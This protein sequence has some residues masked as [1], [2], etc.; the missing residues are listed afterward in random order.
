MPFV[1]VTVSMNI[2]AMVSGPSYRITSSRYVRFF[3]VISSSVSPHENVYG[4]GSITWTTP[5]MPGSFGI[6]RGSPVSCIV[7]LVAPW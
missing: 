4:H 1:P 3:E 7:A 5:G 2:A 6:R